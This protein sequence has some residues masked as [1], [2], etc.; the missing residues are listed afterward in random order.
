MKDISQLTDLE[1]IKYII[2]GYMKEYLFACHEYSVFANETEQTIEVKIQKNE[3]ES[4]FLLLRL[5][6]S[7]KNE[8]IY[9]YNIFLPIEDRGNGFGFGLINV[10][11]SFAGSIS[12]QLVLH[13]MTES[14]YDKMLSRGAM[15][16][17]QED[18]LVVTDETDLGS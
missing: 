6:V 10:L 2:Q 3:T 7:K 1:K 11:F 12:F 15:E 18:C 13:S 17:F 5:G 16:T 8:E 9:L 4:T 14:F